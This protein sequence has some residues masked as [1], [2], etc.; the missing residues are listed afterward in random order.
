VVAPRRA[1]WQSG[2]VTPRIDEIGLP[3]GTPGRLWAAGFTVVGPDPDGALRAVGADTLVTLLQPEE[4]DLRFPAF[5]DWL[6][7]ALRSG[8]AWHVPIDDGGTIDDDTMVA[9]IEE[10]GE[11]LDRGMGLLTHCGAGL[12]RTSL[13]CGA[14][15]VRR[16]VP[17][18]DAL[19]AVRAARPGAG[20]ENP[21][22]RAHLERVAARLAPSDR[23]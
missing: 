20:P 12:G 6:E 11:A 14:L 13:V 21:V 1:A 16:G 19:V 5:A 23:G 15:L 8:R 2:P 4:I 22:Q 18:A 7:G 17:L 10:L 9:A 3:S